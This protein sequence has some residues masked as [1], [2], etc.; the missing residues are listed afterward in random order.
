VFLS[1]GGSNWTAAVCDTSVCWTWTV[2]ESQIGTKEFPII[3]AEGE[4]HDT[5]SEIG[6]YEQTNAVH[7]TGTSYFYDENGDTYP[8]NWSGS[9]TSNSSLWR[10]NAGSTS[11]SNWSTF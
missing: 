11:L 3:Q 10:A 6:G 1:G 2:A 5:G 7:I 8:T 9:F 4:V